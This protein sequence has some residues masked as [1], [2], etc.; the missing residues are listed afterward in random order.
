MSTQVRLVDV[1]CNDCQVDIVKDGWGQRFLPLIER[2]FSQCNRCAEIINATCQ[3]L[4][5]SDLTLA[6]PLSF[7]PEPDRR[8]FAAV[9]EAAHAVVGEHLGMVVESLTVEKHDSVAAGHTVPAAGAVEFDFESLRASKLA[10][11]AAMCVAGMQANQRWLAARGQDTHPNRLE[12]AA[13]GNGDILSLET[14]VDGRLPMRQVLRDARS[15]ADSVITD[16]WGQ[17]TSVARAVLVNGRL[18]RDQV[19]D[20]MH[21]S[22]TRTTATQQDTG[23][24][25]T[26]TIGGEA[27]G[28]DEIRGC[29]GQASGDCNDLRGLLAELYDRAHGMFERLGGVLA[30]AEA[31]E[32]SEALGALGMLLEHASSAA[33]CVGITQ[34]AV[35]VYGGR[36]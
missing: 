30:G 11:Y 9:H 14:A 2:D 17:I 35:E 6:K 23:Q 12:V 32:A 25:A 22:R 24:P 4:G 7:L 3:Q 29:L 31:P 5:T 27:M 15:L 18:D 8:E 21:Q 1:I 36:L 10:D 13:G 16:H 26:T 19:R 33:E 20:V 28:I 34:S